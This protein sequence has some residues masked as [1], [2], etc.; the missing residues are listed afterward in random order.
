MHRYHRLSRHVPV[1][2]TTIFLVVLT[3]F[4]VPAQ[5]HHG[6]DSNFGNLF[7]VFCNPSH[8]NLDDPITG[9]AGTSHRHQY[10]GAKNMNINTTL[11]SARAGGSSCEH[12]PDTA[13]YWVPTLQ[14]SSTGAVVTPSKSF[15]Y[16]IARPNATN[17]PTPGEPVEAAFPE[18]FKMIMGQTVGDTLGTQPSGGWRCAGS[19]G[20]NPFVNRLPNC[21][22]GVIT[23]LNFPN[24]ASLDPEGNIITDS[25]NH[26][27]HVAYSNGQGFCPTSHPVKLP[28]LSIFVHYPT[29]V[30]QDTTGTFCTAYKLSSDGAATPGSTLHSDFWN[31]WDQA[32][33]ERTV[34][35]CLINHNDVKESL[36]DWGC[37]QLFHPGVDSASTVQD[38][39]LLE[40][41]G[42]ESGTL[43]S[44]VVE[45][46][47]TAVSQTTKKNLGTRAA[48]ITSTSTTTRA[49]NQTE[50]VTAGQYCVSANMLADA[51][52]ANPNGVRTEWAFKPTG[53]SFSGPN[54]IAAPVQGNNGGGIAETVWKRVYET[55]TVPSAGTGRVRLAV[56]PESDGTQGSGYFDDVSLTSGAC[57]TVTL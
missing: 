44:W 5:A 45:S 40:N 47:T 8:T 41:G 23:E 9:A 19:S 6:N 31:T 55:V 43:S 11:V 4:A 10:F 32:V 39:G 36:R 14:N 18:D 28:G 15:F 51:S 27:T 57:P 56:F 1:A 34:T 21:P 52:L 17:A 22:N 37:R 29:N 3:L 50:A 7:S 49:I 16:Y 48:K 33:L 13:G 38:D 25:A 2:I 53:G 42:F 12:A 54:V 20:T 26:R 30:C 24:C 46:G 35:E